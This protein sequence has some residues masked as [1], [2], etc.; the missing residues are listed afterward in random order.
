MEAEGL[1]AEHSHPPV[2]CVCGFLTADSWSMSC[3][4]RKRYQT[5]SRSM[6]SNGSFQN[7]T[8]NLSSDPG[9]RVSTWLELLNKLWVLCISTIWGREP[10]G[11]FLGMLHVV[12]DLQWTKYV[13]DPV[14]H[15]AKGC[16]IL[17]L[18]L[19]PHISRNN[20]CIHVLYIKCFARKFKPCHMS[21]KFDW[22]S[23]YYT[24]IHFNL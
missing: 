9:H 5:S 8:L 4:Y 23:S 10:G 12:H 22:N 2:S 16:C 15:L 17:S 21:L 3:I 14:T 1:S 20:E 6:I 18:T 24:F 11:L 19:N 13:S 7:L